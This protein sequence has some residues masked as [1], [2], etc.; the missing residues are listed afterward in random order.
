MTTPTRLTAADFEAFLQRPENADR[1][2]ELIDGEIIEKMP[3]ALHAYLVGLFL[4]ALVGYLKAHPVGYAGAEPRF[5]LGEHDLIPDAAVWRAQPSEAPL[6]EPP[7]LVVEVQSPS[8]SDQFLLRKAQIYLQHG[9]PLVWLVYPRLRIVEAFTPTE[10]RL[11]SASDTL[12]GGD[13]LPGLALSVAD[14]FAGVG[15]S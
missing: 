5:R 1:R 8:Q 7:L 14:V 9:C 12:N 13:V 6:T 15:P 2:L 10:R 3:N 4:H 11:L